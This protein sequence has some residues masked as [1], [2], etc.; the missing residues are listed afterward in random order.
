MQ[1]VTKIL[2]SSSIILG[3]SYVLKKKMSSKKTNIDTSK[4]PIELKHIAGSDFNV[5]QTNKEKVIYESIK[6]VNKNDKEINEDNETTK[7]V[8]ELNEAVVN[9]EHTEEVND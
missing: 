1:S 8:H 5:E 3:L 9:N 6:E 2:I 7:E 4:N